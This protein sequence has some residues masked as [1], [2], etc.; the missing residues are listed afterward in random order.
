MCIRP[1]PAR[2]VHLREAQMRN[3]KAEDRDNVYT[4]PPRPV[5]MHHGRI[6]RKKSVGGFCSALM[7]WFTRMFLAVPR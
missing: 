7:S 3:Q 1:P 5:A 2:L 6:R 4:L